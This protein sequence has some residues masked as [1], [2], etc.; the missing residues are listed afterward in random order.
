MCVDF[1]DGSARTK[2]WQTGGD[3]GWNSDPSLRIYFYANHEEPPEIPL[4]WSQ[5][6]TDSNL[7]IASLSLALTI[8]RG[9]LAVLGF[10]WTLFSIPADLFMA[11]FWS[12]SIAM[13]MSSDL[14]DLEHLSLRP[15]YLQRGCS[16]AKQQSADGGGEGQG[17]ESACVRAQASFVMSLI[18]L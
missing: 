7:A 15:W 12:Y 17:W 1:V 10:D 2:L 18:S 9:I 5:R 11:S 14:S 6:L 8:Q 16:A 3:N 4:I 13:Q